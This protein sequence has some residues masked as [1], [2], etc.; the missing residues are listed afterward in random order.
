MTQT[1]TNA[2]EDFL[3]SQIK[4]KDFRITQLEEQI[5]TVTQRSYTQASELQAMR[6]A[7]HEW[8][9]E[10]L[11]EDCTHRVSEHKKLQSICNFELSKEI[12]VE[13]HVVYNLT[14]S[15]PHGT[16]V[17]SVINDIDFDSVQYGDEVT[18]LSSMIEGVNF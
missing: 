15:V 5:Q 12:D 11:D 4:T 8:T 6:D 7:M 17:E 16:D 13:V 18:Y 1:I 3:K 2:T 14:L 10:Q 9:M